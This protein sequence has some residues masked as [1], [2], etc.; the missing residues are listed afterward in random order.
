MTSRDQPQNP[1]TL[2][3]LNSQSL[4]SETEHHLTISTLCTK[5]LHL[6]HQS[7]SLEPPLS[8]QHTHQISEFLAKFELLRPFGR[9]P[10]R[11]RR[12]WQQCHTVGDSGRRPDHPLASRGTPLSP[13]HD[14]LVPCPLTRPR[15]EDNPSQNSAGHPFSPPCSTASSQSTP[16]CPAMSQR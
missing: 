4:N 12:G 9:A 16:S 6:G 14:F 1:N 7:T 5:V 15:H 10:R 2:L 13:L 8:P 11:R 3:K